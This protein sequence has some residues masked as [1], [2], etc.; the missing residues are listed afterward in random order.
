MTQPVSL[1]STAEV[2]TSV[3]RRANQDHLS[4]TTQRQFLRVHKQFYQ[5]RPHHR[6]SPCLRIAFCSAVSQHSTAHPEPLGGTVTSLIRVFYRSYHAVTAVAAYR[7]ESRIFLFPAAAGAQRLPPP[8]LFDCYRLQSQRSYRRK[9]EV[10]RTPS[11]LHR[12]LLVLMQLL[13]FAQM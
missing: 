4:V 7:S 8:C 5:L 2:Q 6:P 11:A 9:Q 1:R 12:S 3:M 13:S 10:L